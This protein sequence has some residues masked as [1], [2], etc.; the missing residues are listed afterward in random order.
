MKVKNI[1]Y[2]SD[3]QI[4]AAIELLDSID[5]DHN[6]PVNNANHPEHEKSLTAYNPLKKRINELNEDVVKL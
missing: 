3:Q 2:S 4:R 1:M 5:N 6:H